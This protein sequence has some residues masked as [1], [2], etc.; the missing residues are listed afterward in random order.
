MLFNSAAFF[1]QCFYFRICAGM[2]FNSAAYFRICAG[3][4]L[5]AIA[6]EEERRLTII[7]QSSITRRWSI[8]I[9]DLFL[10]FIPPYHVKST[11]R[12]GGPPFEGCSWEDGNYPRKVWLPP[13]PA[14]MV[15]PHQ[16]Q[17]LDIFLL[18]HLHNRFLPK[19]CLYVPKRCPRGR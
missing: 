1:Q 10:P 15:P 9:T 18:A 11:P 3:V 5:N 4:L 8:S 19:L 12:R 6:Y 7:M 13:W 16:L 14:F 2:L 17:L